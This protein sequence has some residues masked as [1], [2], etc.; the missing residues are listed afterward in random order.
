MTNDLNFEFDL[1]SAISASKDNKIL[2][3]TIKYLQ[4]RER[5]KVVL[6][7]IQKRKLTKVHLVR[8]PLSLLKGAVG[9][10]NGEPEP[11][12]L[13]IWLKRVKLIENKIAKKYLPP[14]IIVADFWEKLYIVDGNHRHEA[15]LKKGFNT[16]WT[17]FLLENPDSEI[18]MFKQL[19][20]HKSLINT[21]IVDVGGVLI[22]ES[23]INSRK[24][25]VAKLHITQKQLKKE[26]YKTGKAS[27]ATIGKVKPEQIWQDIK[28]KYNLT[29]S[30]INKLEQDFYAGDKLN[31][32]FFT[33]IRSLH[34]TYKTA[35]LSNAWLDSRKIY[36]KRFHL[37]LIVDQMI[38]S[39]E[40][41]VRK[42]NKK[43]FELALKRLAVSAEETVYV[44][45]HLDNIKT[46]AALGMHT[47]LFTTTKETIEKIKRL[48]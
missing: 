33:F 23:N 24:N 19:K 43:I 11:E 29:T 39:A 26:V 31:N 7:N 30:E 2:D 18:K 47:I 10:Q 13:P 32:S 48:L 35:I 4:S 1:E 14:P 44:D 22:R 46:A 38:I 15:L 21:I 5:N 28:N 17:I 20:L 42:P 16:Y 34:K 41:G 37:D 27:L 12:P 45:D 25:W 6:E 36:T 8:Y 3:W 9:P 40:E